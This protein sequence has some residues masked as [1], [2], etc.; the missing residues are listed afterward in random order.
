MQVSPGTVVSN[1]H[2]DSL[3]W[4][5]PTERR[6]YACAAD[7]LDDRLVGD[8][9]DH[10]VELMS[11]LREFFDIEPHGLQVGICEGT[12]LLTAIGWATNRGLGGTKRCVACV[13]VNDF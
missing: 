1:L 5:A 3:Y 10:R 13:W 6:H 4:R 2:R 12:V 9:L 8:S 11:G 7:M